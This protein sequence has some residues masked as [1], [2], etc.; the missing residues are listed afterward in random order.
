M[1][2]KATGTG[3]YLVQI[4]RAGIPRIRKTFSSQDE[5]EHFEREYLAKHAHAQ[6]ATQEDPRNLTDLAAIWLKYHGLHLADGERR[7]RCLIDMSM[8]LGN[9]RGDQ[10]TAEMFVNYRYK[11]LTEGGLM[12]KTLN[13]HQTY[14]LSMFNKLLKLKLIDYPNPL[15]PVDFIKISERQL[16]YL[17][18]AQI[19]TL[20]QTIKS[21]SDNQ[22]TWYV[23]ALCLR[24]G[25]RWGEVEKLKRK[26][27]HAGR[28]T[29]EFTKSKRTRTIP[30]E[31]KFYEQLM[32]FAAG[33]NPEDRLFKNCIG[34]FR[35]AVKRCELELPRGQNSHILR[36]SFASHFVMGGG[37]ILSLQKILGH[38]EIQMTMRYAHLDADHLQDAVKLNPL[39]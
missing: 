34:S 12:E 24:T 28:V 6:T 25:A 37:N 38:A 5:A 17:S 1:T 9:P 7:H 31:P 15:Q 19:K 27:L 36:H 8:A 4:D 26:Q 39:A 2:V 23:A 32:Q 14:L 13:N 30:L 20:L 35:R 16:S 29:Y 21:G 22:S 18:L 33:K 3:K 11:K 10:L